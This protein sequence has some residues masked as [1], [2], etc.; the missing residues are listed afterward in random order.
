MLQLKKQRFGKGWKRLTVMLAALW[1]SNN[2]HIAQ[3]CF[4]LSSNVGSLTLNSW[5]KAH[6]LISLTNGKC[7]L[8]SIKSKRDEIKAINQI[9]CCAFGHFCWT[10]IHLSAISP[11]LKSFRASLKT[12][13]SPSLCL[14]LRSFNQPLIKKTVQTVSGWCVPLDRPRLPESR[15]CFIARERE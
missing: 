1:S 13:L 3:W 4:E 8:K 6:F 9:W 2:A 15:L 7:G 5:Q 11:M 10:G 12:S 14:Y